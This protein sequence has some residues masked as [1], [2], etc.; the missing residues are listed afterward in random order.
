MEM[1]LNDLSLSDDK[2]FITFIFFVI[3]AETK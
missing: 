1:V 2:S 3:D